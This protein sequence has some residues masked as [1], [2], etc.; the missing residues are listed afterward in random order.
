MIALHRRFAPLAVALAAGCATAEH[1][2]DPTNS[3]TRFEAG[4][5]SGAV[6]GPLGSTPTTNSDQVTLTGVVGNFTRLGIL[7]ADAGTGFSSVY[8]SARDSAGVPHLW[9]INLDGSGLRQLTTGPSG[10]VFPSISRAGDRLVFRDLGLTG[11]QA[12]A[13]DLWEWT[14]VAGSRFLAGETG[15]IGI[16]G[17]VPGDTAIV[18]PV[19]APGDS[20]LRQRNLTGGAVTHLTD[21]PDDRVT[22]GVVDG[23]PTAFFTRHDSLYRLNLATRDTSFFYAPEPPFQAFSADLSP[24]GSHVLFWTQFINDFTVFSIPTDLSDTARPVSFIEPR[25]GA[26]RP[27]ARWSGDTAIV[28]IEQVDGTP[29]P[30]LRFVVIGAGA[31]GL[32]N[33]PGGVENEFTVGPLLLPQPRALIGD[34]GELGS[35]ASGIIYGLGRQ[36]DL[37]SVVSFTGSPQRS[38][39]LRAE[40][41][42]NTEA[43]VLTYSITADRLTSLGYLSDPSDGPAVS[44]IDSSDAAL[45]GALMN[46]DALTGAVGLILTF[47][48][49]NSAPGEFTVTDQDGA[50]V[51]RGRFTAAWQGGRN[52]APGGTREVR[53]SLQSGQERIAP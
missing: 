41:G 24:S 26:W 38:V 23:V 45:S 34:G 1:T 39:S 37:T 20:G 3:E 43:P 32:T 51:F 53:L 21:E 31:R 40:T 2:T 16:A 6:L 7:G 44:V 25:S 11:G 8:F 27:E 15:V 33:L 42:L 17:W 28:V 50:R 22:T 52:L 46:F 36:G 18:Y 49:G 47:A 5:L 19:G 10:Q 12:T 35:R 9:R 13:T 14:P 48:Q 30:Q 4:S 29:V